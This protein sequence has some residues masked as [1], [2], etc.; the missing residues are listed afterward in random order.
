[1]SSYV[2]NEKHQMQDEIVDVFYQPLGDISPVIRNQL[3]KLNNRW[4]G[5]ML[6][7][8]MPDNPAGI[9]DAVVFYAMSPTGRVASWA[10]VYKERGYGSNYAT[11]VDFYTK[12]SER[13]K[14]YAS[15]IAGV[16]RGVYP[17]AR[18]RG[19][20]D[21]STIFKRYSIIED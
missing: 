20:A 21:C 11:I 17:N 18:L 8:L 10:M 1:M 19:A 15:C 7:H 2:G 12:K 16:I 9:K 3:I 5:R 13:K 4:N 14:N 6:D